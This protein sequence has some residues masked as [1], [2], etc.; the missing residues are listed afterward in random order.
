[1]CVCVCARVCVCAHACVHVCVR[2]KSQSQCVF[3]LQAYWIWPTATAY[4]NQSTHSVH[5]ST[6]IYGLQ[7]K[8]MCVCVCVMCVCVCGVCVHVRARVGMCVRVKS[9]SQCGFNLQAY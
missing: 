4:L 3:N 6:S 8:T 2:V 1:M 7:N 5:R 9:Q